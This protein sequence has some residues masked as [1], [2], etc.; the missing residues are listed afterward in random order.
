MGL[1]LVTVVIPTCSRPERLRECLAALARQTM[2]S[3]AYE[4]LVV[5][6]GSNHPVAPSLA[7]GNGGAP[8]RVIRQS[9][10]GPAAARN[11]GV[12][13]ARGG[14]VAFTDDDCLPAPTWI[15]S[16]VHAH[17]QCPAALVG[18]V[19]VNGLPDD[20]FATTSQMIVD[21]VYEHFNADEQSAV[22]LTSNNMLCSRATYLELGGFDASFERP[23]AEDRDFCDRWRHSG[24]PMR[25]VRAATLEHR[26]A[27]SL[28]QF[29]ELHYRYGRGAF[30]FQSLRRSRASGSLRGDATFHASLLQRLPRHLQPRR[31]L[32]RTGQIASALALWQLANAMGFFREAADHVLRGRRAISRSRRDVTPYPAP[33]QSQP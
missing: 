18:G 28:R 6:D 27:Q 25:V 8:V 32:G 14:L 23:G 20:L 22:F 11:R 21:L 10:A 4:I 16:L 30:L 5:D 12:Q 15:E 19:T 29:L 31:G 9:N 24:R 7:P 3:H 17:R 33:V 2:P 13:E 1:P 26:H